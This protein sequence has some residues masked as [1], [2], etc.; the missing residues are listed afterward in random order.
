MPETNIDLSIIVPAYNEAERLPKTLR[1]LQEYLNA[2][3]LSYEILIILDGPTDNTRKV[4]DG[5]VSEMCGVRILEWKVNRGKG[6]AVKT[7]MLNARG[8]VRL[9]TDA[10]NS[11]DISHL[12]Q[13]LVLFEQDHDLVI[14]SRHP[15]DAAGARQVVPQPRHKRLIG[16]LGNLFIRLVAVRGIW[17]TQCGFKGFRDYAAEKLF[18]QSSIERWGFDIE[19][20]ALAKAVKYKIGI[21]PAYWVNDLRSHVGMSGY[22]DSFREMLLVRRNLS[23]GKYNL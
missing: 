15:R 10:D 16:S 14:C 2:R 18:S 1:R 20:L 19:I 22:L 17:D 12:E 13:M 7:G 8:R 4:L 5:M 11:T 21:V 3:D 6:Y 9:F 23:R